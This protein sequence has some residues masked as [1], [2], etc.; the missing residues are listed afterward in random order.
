MRWFDRWSLRLRTLFHRRQVERELGAEFEFHVE[1]QTAENLAAGMSPQEARYAALRSTGAITQMQ[2]QCRDQ[3]GL[4]LIETTLQDIR[5]AV[6]SLRKS[7]GFTAV[8]VIS[9]ALGMGANAAIFS[10]I[11]SILLS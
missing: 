10:L 7:P 5:Y 11:D 3:R 2:E 9:L 4:H 1:Q 6:R 8:A